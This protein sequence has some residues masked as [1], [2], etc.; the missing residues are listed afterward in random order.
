VHEQLLARSEDAAQRALAGAVERVATFR[1]VGQGHITA[2]DAL[3]AASAAARAR[4]QREAAR[5]AL[6]VSGIN[7]RTTE[8]GNDGD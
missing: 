5:E 2:A 4:E 6:A 7:G 3:L 8:G 1:Y